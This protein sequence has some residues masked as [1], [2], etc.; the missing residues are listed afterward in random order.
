[1]APSTRKRASGRMKRSST[2]TAVLS[3]SGA[4]KK[5][6]QL[7]RARIASALK[8]DNLSDLRTLAR[9]PLGLVDEA[10]R[11]QVWPRLVGVQPH[12]SPPVR[13]Q[14]PISSSSSASSTSNSRSGGDGGDGDVASRSSSSS[15]TNT[16]EE[17]YPYAAQIQLDVDRSLWR[18]P[19]RINHARRLQLRRQLSGVMAAFFRSYG[20]S[21]HYYQGLHEI[22]AV[23]MLN[24]N[25]RVA[26]DMLV[27]L[28]HCHLRDHMG[29]DMKC[30]LAQLNL[31][32]AI[33]ARADPEL[34]EFLNRAETLPIFALSWPLTW[35]CHVVDSLPNVSRI[36]DACLAS[37]PFFPLYLSAAVVLWRRSDVMQGPCRMEIVYKT[38]GAIPEC[39]WSQHIEAL[40]ANAIE[41]ETAHPVPDLLK[42]SVLNPDDTQRLTN[43][44]TLL[45][46]DAFL[47][48]LQQRNATTKK[49][50]KAKL[51]PMPTTLTR[52][53]V[54]V[55]VAMVVIRKGAA[56]AEAL[57]V[58]AQV[59]VALTH[60]QQRRRE[61]EW[62]YS[63]T[64]NAAIPKKNCLGQ[65]QW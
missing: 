12:L 37:H 35:F 8:A 55:V 44:E 56:V 49:K 65:L 4:Q 10:T 43:S 15:T 58:V 60:V 25:M 23:L 38:L 31:M 21:L 30:T 61:E 39:A 13:S 27:R 26:A 41:L 63:K 29:R 54:V 18:F 57:L 9:G 36:F 42:S 52:A 45:R 22:A 11:R 50:K 20:N 7:Q 2:A 53:V 5:I 34:Y 46:H 62:H 24:T 47:A 16:S 59:I 14:S 64:M 51:S 40:I 48:R 33:V 1:M 19:L 28:A 3:R 17:D 6:Q 32:L